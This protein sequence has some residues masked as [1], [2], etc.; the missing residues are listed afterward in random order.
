[1]SETPSSVD[2]NSLIHRIVTMETDD[3]DDDDDNSGRSSAIDMPYSWK[4]SKVTLYH[5]R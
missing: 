5:L 1:M 3:D 4:F 2:V